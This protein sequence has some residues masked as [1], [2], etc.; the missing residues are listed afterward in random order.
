M[1][2]FVIMLQKLTPVKLATKHTFIVLLCFSVANFAFSAAFYSGGGK[3]KENA[4]KS[5]LS[6]NTK[7]YSLLS[8]S[9]G[10]QFKGGNSFS[11]MSAT[12]IHLN[13]NT[14]YYQKGNNIYVIPHKHKVFFSKFK[15]PEKDL[16]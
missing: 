9:N 15:T 7:N 11:T 13:T 12:G 14:M 3:K 2:K 10:F 6:F 5:S 16:K 1:F 4:K 8:F